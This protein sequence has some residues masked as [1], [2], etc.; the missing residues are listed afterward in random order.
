MTEGK[1]EIQDPT[2]AQNIMLGPKKTSSKQKGHC[3]SYYSKGVVCVVCSLDTCNPFV[4]KLSVLLGLLYFL[5]KATQ[6]LL[7]KQRIC[8]D[9]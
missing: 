3:G 4:V 2:G 8:Q 7:Y 9:G 5:L 1:V 6:L